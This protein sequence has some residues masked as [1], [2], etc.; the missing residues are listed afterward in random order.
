M[1]NLGDIIG[2]I[3][4]VIMTVSLIFAAGWLQGGM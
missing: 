1:P 3:C 4:G 2:G